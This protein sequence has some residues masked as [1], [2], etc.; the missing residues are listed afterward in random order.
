MHDEE[1]EIANGKLQMANLKFAFCNLPSCPG[2]KP[3]SPQGVWFR[4]RLAGLPRI[5]TLT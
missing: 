3:G 2:G 5:L 1:R 4:D